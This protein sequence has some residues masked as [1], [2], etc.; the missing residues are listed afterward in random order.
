MKEK[1]FL[2]KIWTLIAVIVFIML[3]VASIGVVA[4]RITNA[5]PEGVDAYFI[6]ARKPSFSVQNGEDKAIWEE[7][8]QISIF[9]SAYQNGARET[10]VLSQ[11]GDAIIAP[12]TISTYEFIIGNQGNMAIAYDLDFSFVLTMNG[13]EISAGLFPLQVRVQ[14]KNAEFVL[15]GED[16]WKTIT[17]EKMG[18]VKGTLGASSYEH[19]VLELQWAFEGNDAL[20]TALGNQ[21]TLYPVSLDFEIGSYAEEHTDPKAQGGIPY[22]QDGESGNQEVGG[23]VRWDKYL[24]LLLASGVMLIVVIYLL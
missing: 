13:E 18:E 21:T 14:R 23:V 20:D 1:S 6:T 15:G 3:W 4:L 11:N 16:E 5:L 12:G 19:F 10:T 8:N 24:L 9:Q 7:N 17:S 22:S 2:E